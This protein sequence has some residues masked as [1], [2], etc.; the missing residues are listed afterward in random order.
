MSIQRNYDNNINY[1]P[2]LLDLRLLHIPQ[3]KL[4]A[5]TPSVT[6]NAIEC[7]QQHEMTGDVERKKNTTEELQYIYSCQSL[8]ILPATAPIKNSTPYE[9]LQ[10]ISAHAYVLNVFCFICLFPLVIEFSQGEHPYRGCLYLLTCP[11]TNS[12]FIFFN[13]HHKNT[14]WMTLGMAMMSLMLGNMAAI[15]YCSS[16]C[17]LQ[18]SAPLNHS[19]Y[20]I[21]FG[22]LLLSTALIIGAVQLL[23][24]MSKSNV[25]V[26]MIS[27][28]SGVV[29]CGLSLAAI[30][31]PSH[32]SKRCYQSSI[33]CI[34]WL[35]WQA[36]Q[37]RTS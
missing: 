33:P 5:H 17:L 16:S 11:I 20:G 6:I 8:P 18:A 34:L 28:A 10:W 32:I 14:K 21:D 1:Q 35:F 24:L 22:L 13:L 3:N 23:L 36:S 30:F 26:V 29:V 2:N 7:G 25:A 9:I 4:F 19:L 37:S 15:L 12:S 31:L 27:T